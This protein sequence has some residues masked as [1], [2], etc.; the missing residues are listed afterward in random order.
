[1]SDSTPV[2]RNFA[3]VVDGV[4]TEIM[5]INS[6]PEWNRYIEMYASRPTIIEIPEN[7]EDFGKGYT[8]DGVNFNPPTE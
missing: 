7:I 3:F 5:S 2:F 6:G 4:V 8:W 1:M